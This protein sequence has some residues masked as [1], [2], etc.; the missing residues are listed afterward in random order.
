MPRLHGS[1][2][3]QFNALE[4]SAWSKI[5]IEMVIKPRSLHGLLL[6]NGD[7]QD[8]RGDYIL[9]SLKNGFVELRFDCGTGEAVIR[10]AGFMYLC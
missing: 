10:Y 4:S 7:R 2:F 1:G 6:F 5:D 8:G 3:L 9:V